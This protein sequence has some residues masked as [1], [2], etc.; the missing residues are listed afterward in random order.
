MTKAKA[1]SEYD[2]GTTIPNA[3]LD[4]LKQHL[5]KM[6]TQEDLFGPEG[7]VKQLSAAL[8]ERC[9]AR[10]SCPR[11]WATTPRTRLNRSI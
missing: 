8:I 10:P 5:P 9:E 2:K 3:L 7:V 11:T 6:P 4:E 1:K